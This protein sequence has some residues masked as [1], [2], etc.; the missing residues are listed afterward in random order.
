[1]IEAAIFF[2]IVAI[3]AG[4]LGFTN[5]AAGAAAIAKI[6]F[7]VALVIFLILVVLFFMGIAIIA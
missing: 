3:I 5:V 2:L 6:F 7:F 4:V 1:M